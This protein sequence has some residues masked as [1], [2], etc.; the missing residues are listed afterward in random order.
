M[1][2]WCYFTSKYLNIGYVQ[3]REFIMEF[4]FLYSRLKYL[5][6]AQNCRKPMIPTNTTQYNY[7]Y[8]TII[9]NCLFNKIEVLLLNILN[10]VKQ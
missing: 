3:K 8:A 4:F 9:I 6:V 2:I 10:H 7:Y 5:T 1:T